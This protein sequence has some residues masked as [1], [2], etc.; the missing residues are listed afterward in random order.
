M[1]NEHKIEFGWKEG[2][3]I[4][5]LLTVCFLFFFYFP[6]QRD[7][8]LQGFKTTGVIIGKHMKQNIRYRYH[9]RDSTY[10]GTAHASGADQF[11]KTQ[12]GEVYVVYVD[13]TDPEN[14]T[15]LLDQQVRDKDDYWP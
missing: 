8:A 4:A 11:M 15:I 3:S 2:L 5:V 13:T 12:L 1:S 7:K 14:S 9:Y 6:R 10:T